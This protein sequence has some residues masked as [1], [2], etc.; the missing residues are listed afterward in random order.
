MDKSTLSILLIPVAAA[1][2]YWGARIYY[3]MTFQGSLKEVA[4]RRKKAE[5]LSR[6]SRTSIVLALLLVGA[7]LLL[8]GK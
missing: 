1:N 5:Q 7:F 4:V 8:K 2:F 6:L 3:L